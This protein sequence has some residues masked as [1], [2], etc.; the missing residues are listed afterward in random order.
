MAGNAPTD[1]T[2][3]QGESGASGSHLATG[4]GQF[5]AIESVAPSFGVE[6][7]DWRRDANEIERDVA[8]FAGGPERRL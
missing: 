5:G 6:S 3:L 7:P 2:R 4:I 8:A 1:L